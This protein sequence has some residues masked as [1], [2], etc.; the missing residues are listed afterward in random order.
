MCFHLGFVHAYIWDYG[1]DNERWTSSHETQA[2]ASEIHHE[3]VK[4][5]GAIQYRHKVNVI[6]LFCSGGEFLSVMLNSLQ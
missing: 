3:F 5:N 2:I 1:T 4:N 6:T